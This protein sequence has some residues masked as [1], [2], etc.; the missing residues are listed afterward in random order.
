ML[1]ILFSPEEVSEREFLCF[2]LWKLCC[3]S[4]ESWEVVNRLL[5]NV[6]YLVFWL[7]LSL[8]TQ[9]MPFTS[10]CKELD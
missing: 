6:F 2:P 7:H 4:V 10:L 3:H 1:S 8:L 9:T 5:G